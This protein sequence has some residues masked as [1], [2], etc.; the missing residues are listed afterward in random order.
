LFWIVPII[1][2]EMI[3]VESWKKSWNFSIK[4]NIALFSQEHLIF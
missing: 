4:S 1:P 2:N 3:W